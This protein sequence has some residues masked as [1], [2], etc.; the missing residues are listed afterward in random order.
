MQL[1]SISSKLLLAFSVI[2]LVILVV[3]VTVTIINATEQKNNAHQQLVDSTNL[4]LELID[5]KALDA[6]GIALAYSKD[7]R[8]ID[9]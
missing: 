6:E 5:K 1:K 2:I 8:I 4:L 9:A 3:L 7:P